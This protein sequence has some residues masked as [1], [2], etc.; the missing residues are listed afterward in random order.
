MDNACGSGEMELLAARNFSVT[1]NGV[2]LG[3]M[4]K[5]FKRVD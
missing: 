3:T 1:G 4:G 5:N 2:E